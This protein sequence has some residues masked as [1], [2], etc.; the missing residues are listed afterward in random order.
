MELKRAYLG[1]CIHGEPLG[2]PSTGNVR[3]RNS[4]LDDRENES[5]WVAPHWPGVHFLRTR[6]SSLVFGVGEDVVVVTHAVGRHS[7]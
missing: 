1:P 5:G 7:R 4:P 6:G 2:P 3:T